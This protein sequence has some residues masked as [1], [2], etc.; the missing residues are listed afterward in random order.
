[1]TYFCGYYSGTANTSAFLGKKFDSIEK[2]MIYVKSHLDYFT[3][4]SYGFIVYTDEKIKEG[5]HY[6]P[7]RLRTWHRDGTDCAGELINSAI[8]WRIYINSENNIAEE[9]FT[10][11]GD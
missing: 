11:K 2:V 9:H 10:P 8:G 3:A 6:V 5:R 1:M 4:N 7:K